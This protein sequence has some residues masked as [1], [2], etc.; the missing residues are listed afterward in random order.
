MSTTYDPEPGSADSEGDQTLDHR[1]PWPGWVAAFAIAGMGVGV[2]LAVLF[3]FAA[4]ATGAGS[5]AVLSAGVLG[6]YGTLLATCA[7]VVAK[8]GTGRG[9]ASDLGLRLRW[10]DLWH[11]FL[12]GLGARVVSV[13]VVLP[14]VLIDEDLAGSNLPRPDELGGGTG[15]AIGFFLM[16]VVAAPFV[17]ELFFRGLVQ[18]S[19]ETVVPAWFA[20]AG[21]ALLFGVAHAS[22]DLGAGNASVIVATAAAGVVFGWAARR[23]GRLGPSIAGHAWFNLPAVAALFW[24]L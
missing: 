15:I 13:L 1:A 2:V 22:L 19:L 18:R 3:G 6:L 9:F 17:E 24:L 7:A 10:G 4:D 21:A 20:I 23:N 14:M 16:A 5:L 11:G 12:L 8:T